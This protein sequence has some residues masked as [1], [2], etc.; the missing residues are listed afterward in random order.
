[1]EAG[2]AFGQ[3]GDRHRAT[4]EQ[5]EGEDGQHRRKV[6]DRD[7]VAEQPWQA[8]SEVTTVSTTTSQ[9]ATG[10][11]NR[12]AVAPLVAVGIGTASLPRWIMIGSARSFR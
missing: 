12:S 2:P 6:A 5:G 9:M 4:E 10:W 1:M 8:E 3:G 7:A 11:D